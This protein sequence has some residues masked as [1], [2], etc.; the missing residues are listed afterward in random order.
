MWSCA[1]T[2]RG[3]ESARSDLAQTGKEN[4]RNASPEDIASNEALR[5]LLQRDL[6]QIFDEQELTPDQAFLRL[7]IDYLGYNP[8]VGIVSDGKGDKGVDFIEVTSSGASII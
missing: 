6:S 4:L 1:A 2:A 3:T 7:C 8:E 5:T